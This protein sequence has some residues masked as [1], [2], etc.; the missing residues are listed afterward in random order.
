[1]DRGSG[2]GVCKARGMVGDFMRTIRHKSYEHEA[3][4]LMEARHK[5]PSDPDHIG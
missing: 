4:K 5:P 2:R 1:M 3:A